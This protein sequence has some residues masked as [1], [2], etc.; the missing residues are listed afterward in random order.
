M[1]L[2]EI[3]C[4]LVVAVIAFPQLS[5]AGPAFRAVCE[6]DNVVAFRYITDFSGKPSTYG[7]SEG[8]KFSGLWIFVYEGGDS[9]LIDGK[10]AIVI[11]SNGPSIVAIEPGMAQ[12]GVGV[13]SY[14]I[15]TELK[16]IVAA[17]VNGFSH[18]K[19][20]SNGVKTRSVSFK[21][22]FTS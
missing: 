17:Q 14:V 13:W 16:M 10:K 22:I 3:V 4:A 11:G 1:K 15:H 2:R 18:G 20:S 8:E 6:D 5:L 7:W 12:A 19:D 9:M 21:C